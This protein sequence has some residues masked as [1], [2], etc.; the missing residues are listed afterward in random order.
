MLVRTL[1]TLLCIY[2]FSF[3]HYMAQDLI[4]LKCVDTISVFFEK[5]NAKVQNL[6][7][8]KQKLNSNSVNKGTIRFK[9]YID[10][11]QNHANSHRLSTK[12]YHEIST[13]ITNSELQTLDVDTINT[14]N[15]ALY[16]KKS[17]HQ[18]NQVDIFLYEYVTTIEY[19]KPI[20]SKISYTD[21]TSWMLP[22][23]KKEMNEI[24]TLMK[25][26]PSL[27]LSILSNICCN[28]DYNVIISRADKI[29]SFLKEKGIDENRI[30]CAVF[31]KKLMEF[32]ITNGS[33]PAEKRHGIDLMFSK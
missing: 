28:M 1:L 20:K 30:T 14:L 17:K 32:Y 12:R 22:E 25:N 27:K 21:G 10:S 24:F 29:K 3:T 6:D 33:I 9:S 23:S 18:V 15:Q 2:V 5:G 11:N 26:D 8:L 13:L 16:S 7:L 31:D 4:Q 19:N